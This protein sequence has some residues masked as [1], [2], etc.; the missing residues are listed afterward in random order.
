MMY[1]W[2]QKGVQDLLQ[3]AEAR[4]FA[5]ALCVPSQSYAR[6]ITRLV[7][8]TDDGM[9]GNPL[10]KING[11]AH[12]TGGGIWGKFVELLP[13]GVGAYLDS[14]PEPAP[15]LQRGWELSQ[16]TPVQ[17]SAWRAYETTHGGCGMLLV[18]Q[19]EDVSTIIAEAAK[20][21]IKAQVVGATTASEKRE[22]IIE[23]R[24]FGPPRTLSSL[25]PE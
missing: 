23:S 17:K 16:G 14:M 4:E 8:W 21:G 22:T 24:F 20:D 3:N 6:T 18:C 15:V 5:R 25:C 12:I 10:A 1:L 11:I 13:A 2:G 7:G 9:A 19:P